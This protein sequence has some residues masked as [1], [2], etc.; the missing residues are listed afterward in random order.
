MMWVWFRNVMA[1]AV[2]CLLCGVV[3]GQAETL[4]L[5]TEGSYPPFSSTQPDGTVAGFDIDIAK[6]LCLRIGARCEIIAQD[7][8]GIIPG[9]LARRYDLISASL[10]ITEERKQKVAFTDPYYKAAIA[11]VVPKGS[12]LRE[13]TNETLRGR[14]I[15][16]QASS[17]QAKFVAKAYPDADIRLYPTQEEASLDMLS[18]RLDVLVGDYFPLQDFVEKTKEGQCCMI[19]G[20]PVTDPSW[21]GEGAAIAVRKDDDQLRL[22]LNKALAEIIED[23]TYQKI[24]DR[25]FN[26]NVMRF[27]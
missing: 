7:W 8:D 17:N 15:G 12:A 1:G 25:Y 26:V 5:A 16:A 19:A 18:G 20:A 3:T 21:V 6:E 24:N 14:A 13:F 23:G 22:R 2:L 11:H 27:E 10:F 9:L 4:K